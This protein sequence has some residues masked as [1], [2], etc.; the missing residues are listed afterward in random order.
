MQIVPNLFAFCKIR[1]IANKG[2]HG[3][4]W[5]PL[6]CNLRVFALCAF[7]LCESLLYS[8]G[9]S[10]I[11]RRPTVCQIVALTQKISRWT[12]RG[13]RIALSMA[14]ATSIKLRG[15]LLIQPDSWTNH[16]ATRNQ[17]FLRLQCTET[18]WLSSVPSLLIRAIRGHRQDLLAQH[19]KGGRKIQKK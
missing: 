9:L 5:T 8:P 13:P 16:H 14:V 4:R 7:A 1:D 15:S 18:R 3:G 11:Y 12:L 2:W 19:I 17:V 6:A 10:K